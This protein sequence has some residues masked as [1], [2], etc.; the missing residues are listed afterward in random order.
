LTALLIAEDSAGQPVLALGSCGNLP[1]AGVVGFD[2]RI[3]ALARSYSHSIHL[4][5]LDG[6][7]V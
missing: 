7:A 1:D 6:L 3:V 2:Y 4:D 5:R